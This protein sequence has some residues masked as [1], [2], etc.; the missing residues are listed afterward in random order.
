MPRHP[1]P[2]ADG[3]VYQALNR[4]NKVVV[5]CSRWGRKTRQPLTKLLKVGI[6]DGCELPCIT[7]RCRS[8][9][10]CGARGRVAGHWT[11]VWLWRAVAGR[12]VATSERADSSS[13]PP[14]PCRWQGD[15][16]LP[17]RGI[18]T[19]SP[20]TPRWWQ[21]PAPRKHRWP[22]EDSFHSHP[23]PPRRNESD[24]NHFLKRK[25][26]GCHVQASLGLG[27]RFP[28]QSRVRGAHRNPTPT[29]GRWRGSDSSV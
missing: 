23:P 13:S 2:I 22:L 5:L 10:A 26:G 29:R 20:P 6:L 16:R 4:G 24:E 17:A 1:R 19:S 28:R 8:A 14:T 3:L 25:R 9:S 15:W 18:S 11:G 27:L 12:L 21:G 7:W